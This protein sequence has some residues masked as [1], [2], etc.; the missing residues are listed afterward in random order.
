MRMF[1]GCFMLER[2][3]VG[4]QCEVFCMQ[5]HTPNF[6][7]LPKPILTLW[8][9][10]LYLGMGHE[11]MLLQAVPLY[12]DRIPH[13]KEQPTRKCL[14]G[15]GYFLVPAIPA[16]AGAGIPSLVADF[17]NFAVSPRLRAPI[18]TAQ[19]GCLQ[20]VCNFT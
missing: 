7:N 16:P 1:C 13:E 8:W 6:P 5:P 18:Q 11:I 19:V 4:M 15:P 17:T 14:Y 10:P 9:P 20:G 2:C 3:I 12:M